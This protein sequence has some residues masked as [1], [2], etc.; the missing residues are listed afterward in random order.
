MLQGVQK[1]ISVILIGFALTSVHAGVFDLLNSM[2]KTVQLSSEIDRVPAD[3]RLM[4]D[5][6]VRYNERTGFNQSPNGPRVIKIYSADVPAKS[7]S[8]TAQSKFITSE[9]RDFFLHNR[10]GEEYVRVFSKNPISLSDGAIEGPTY[11]GTKVTSH[12][13]HLV[14]DPEEPL[15]KR[16]Y[17]KLTDSSDIEPSKA[18]KSVA[19]SDFLESQHWDP[20]KYGYILPERFASY[21]EVGG[22]KYSNIAREVLPPNYSADPDERFLPGHSVRDLDNPIWEEWQEHGGRA[23][24]F[25]EGFGNWLGHLHFGQGVHP[26]A[27]G[28]NTLM[29][30]NGTNGRIR[31]FG[32]RDMHDTA[33]D[34]MI[35]A[36][37]GLSGAA[38]DLLDMSILNLHHVDLS[39]DNVSLP[40]T[41][42]EILD[43]YALGLVEGDW[44]EA[45]FLKGYQ[46]AAS[47]YVPNLNLLMKPN[48]NVEN[49]NNIYR[50]VVRGLAERAMQTWTELPDSESLQ[51]ILKSRLRSKHIGLPNYRR[52]ET[53][54]E[55]M[56]GK[57]GL[58]YF[59]NGDH[60]LVV[61]RENRPVVVLPDLVAWEKGSVGIAS[62][63]KVPDKKGCGVSKLAS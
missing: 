41:A 47:E 19:M 27:H 46:R 8:Q 53:P 5:Q 49:I 59:S 12:S 18:G 62:K 29:Q 45:K 14:W 16:Y 61:D 39:R 57:K 11:L 17:I 2:W 56:E 6:D 43:N 63:T 10:D 20:D 42:G 33:I 9:M 23:D 44:K 60:L 26:E 13:T 35:R 48:R 55:R 38:P 1:S 28:Q 31:R 30:V 25:Y 58:R 3:M 36:L 15:F 22:K 37:R 54:E 4:V 51:H 32:F 40:P 52:D 24:D 34:P 21:V 7:N 50:S